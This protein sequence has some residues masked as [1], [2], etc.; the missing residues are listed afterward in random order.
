MLLLPRLLLMLFSLLTKNP[1]NSQ[2][3]D[4]N[5]FNGVIIFN[6]RFELIEVWS[7]RISTPVCTFIWPMSLYSIR[8]Q[9]LTWTRYK[10]QI[11]WPPAVPIG[12]WKT[13]M[14]TVHGQEKD[15]IRELWF[16]IKMQRLEYEVFGKVQGVFF[17]KY[18][19]KEADKLKLTGWVMNTDKGTVVGVADG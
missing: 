3:D 13:P 2:I 4:L 9:F 19:K 16:Q 18:T 1:K 15:T 14:D 8:P 12:L 11:L 17:R 7:C 5:Y 10:Q 6:I